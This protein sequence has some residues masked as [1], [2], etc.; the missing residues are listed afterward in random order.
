MRRHFD[1]ADCKPTC[2]IH[3]L[4]AAADKQAQIDIYTDD[5][6]DV[7]YTSH[8]VKWKTIC[9]KTVRVFNFAFFYGFSPE[10]LFV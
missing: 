6:S 3:D 7:Y 8:L 5:L 1:V 10:F 2:R 9:L 4:L